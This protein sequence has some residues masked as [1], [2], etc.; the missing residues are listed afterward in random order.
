MTLKTRTLEVEQPEVHTLHIEDAKGDVRQYGFHLGTIRKV[1]LEE[2]EVRA[3]N[4][5]RRGAK[6]VALKQGG[7]LIR[8]FDFRDL[9]ESE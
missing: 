7:R 5:L 3:L 9:M 2:G 1:A 4:K 8:M 6:S